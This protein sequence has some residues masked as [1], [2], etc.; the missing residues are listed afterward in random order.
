MIES[1]E[2]IGSINWFSGFLKRWGEKGQKVG[3]D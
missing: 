1:H 2:Y 3:R